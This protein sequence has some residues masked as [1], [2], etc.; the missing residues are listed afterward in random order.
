[1]P[2]RRFVWTPDRARYLLFVII[3]LLLAA[4]YSGCSSISQLGGTATPTATET[5]T[6][7]PTATLTPTPTPTP[8]IIPPPQGEWS[9]Y[10]NS[11]QINDLE[12]DG[13]GYLWGRGSGS[14]IRWDIRDGTYQEYGLPEG[15]PSNTAGKIFLGP[16][17]EIWIVYPEDGL[18]QQAGP[19]WITHREFGEIEGYRVDAT[20]VGPDGKLWI[21]SDESLSSFDGSDW[22]SLDVEGGMASGFC[23]YLTVDLQG[24]PLMQGV[25]G[26]SVYQ[27][28]DWLLFELEGLD[29]TYKNPLGAYTAPNGDLWFIYGDDG[30]LSY[31]DGAWY[32]AKIDPK[33]F[34]ISTAGQVWMIQDGGFSNPDYLI[35]REL[36]NFFHFDLEEGGDPQFVYGIHWNHPFHD[37]MP[38]ENL[39][40]IYPGINNDIWITCKEGLLH[41]VGNRI[42]LIPIESIS[43]YSSIYDLAIN[44]FGQVFIALPDGISQVKGDKLIPFHIEVDLLS[45]SFDLITDTTGTLW[46]DTSKGFQSFDG[47][48]WVEHDQSPV[49]MAAAPNGDLWIASSE[50]VSQWDGSAWVDYSKEGLEG[51]LDGTI[52]GLHVG[53]DGVVWVGV[54]KKGI[55]YFDGGSWTAIPVENE[56]ALYIV[57]GI[58]AD[59]GGTVYL[60]SRTKE[61]RQPVLQIIRDNKWESQKLDESLVGFSRHPD[62]TLW[63]ALKDG[64]YT[65]EDGKL[66][67]TSLALPE[68]GITIRDFE[69]SPDGSLWIGT[70]Q[71]AYR[72]DGFNW[73]RYT[74]EDGLRSNSVGDLAIGPDNTIWFAGSGLTRFGP[75]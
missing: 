9:Q 68:E 40:K 61:D 23:K 73:E 8:T 22:F 1:M 25:H 16:K 71:G 24:I 7:T 45:N 51:L 38:S 54:Y 69:I 47:E 30:E 18:W 3:G 46:L 74:E 17:N 2:A 6:P 70:Y 57:Y 53:E 10:W 42:S 4:V 66:T 19:D 62:G 21:C 63:M 67:K 15:M 5:N 29:F 58:A 13:Q 72:Y 64:L 65:L 36:G 11:N 44:R 48:T 35:R 55:S 28:P 31:E 52:G 14:L 27:E 26:V 59:S 41:Q 20:A 43:Y 33:D 37:R 50:G 34:G 12:F 32:R 39:G 60:V 75:P 49:A 56:D